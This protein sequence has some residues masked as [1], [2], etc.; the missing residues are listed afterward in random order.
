MNKFFSLLAAILF[1]AVCHAQLNG[2]GYYRIQ[3]VKTERFIRVIDNYG[4]INVTSTSADM[5]ALKT[6]K[7]F[8]NIVSDPSSV[9]YF[10]NTGSVNYNL[11]SQGTSLY[12]IIHYYVRIQDNGNGTYKAYAQHY[13][14][15][16]YLNDEVSRRV[17]GVVSNND[18]T[19]RDWYIK[20]VTL[21]EGLYFGLQPDVTAGSDRYKS[22]FAD[23]AFTFASSGMTAYFVTTIDKEKGVA[24]YEKV[25]GAV[26]AATP[27]F[28]KCASAEPAGNK[29]NL[30]A[31]SPAALNGNKL[32]G[33][34]FCNPNA[35]PLHTNVVTYNAETMRVLGTTAKG[36]LGWVKATGLTYIPANTAYLTVDADTPADLKLVSKEEYA[37]MGGNIVKGDA[38]DD[39]EIDVQDIMA[40]VSYLMGEQPASFNFLSADVNGDGIIDVRDLVGLIDLVMDAGLTVTPGDANNDGTV[41]VQDIVTI[42][43]YLM[44]EQ[45]T[46]FSDKG[47]DV[48]GDNTIDIRDLVGL[49]DIMM[50]Q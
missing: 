50:K 47:A 32:T 10:K 21:D 4:K 27:V 44:D 18:A 49:I 40:I 20:P 1:S 34:Y 39:D 5:G 12:D 43:S 11:K 2:D 29:L 30:Q 17:D 25:S 23:F 15:T 3:N 6:L 28:V 38:N 24:V 46:P 35:G 14:N 7:G 22:F 9:I 8:D 37:A 41:D 45:P 13:G 48:N 42:V 26:P 36:E 31:S 33:V 16:I 19:S